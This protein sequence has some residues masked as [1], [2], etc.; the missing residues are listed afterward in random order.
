M[1]EVSLRSRSQLL[2]VERSIVR[3]SIDSPRIVRLATDGRSTRAAVDFWKGAIQ[4]D[5]DLGLG[6]IIV[7]LLDDEL[8]SNGGVQSVVARRR[9]LPNLPLCR[10]STAQSVQGLC[11]A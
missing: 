4:V 9:T 7:S 6:Q 11:I 2:G 3:S 1:V 10:E 5:P 8:H